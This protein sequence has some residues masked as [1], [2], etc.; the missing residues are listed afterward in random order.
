MR[1]DRELRSRGPLQNEAA[2]RAGLDGAARLRL[3]E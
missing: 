1:M 2:G 3:A